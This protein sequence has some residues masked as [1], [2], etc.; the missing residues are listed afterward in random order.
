[1]WQDKRVRAAS[2]SQGKRYAERW[3]A[4]WVL[5]GGP[6]K[7]AVARL[8]VNGEPARALSRTEIQQQRRLNAIP[9]PTL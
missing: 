6:L 1:M 9:N 5:E 8:V 4:A 2:V 3:C 7:E